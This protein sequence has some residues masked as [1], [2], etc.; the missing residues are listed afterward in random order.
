MSRPCLESWLEFLGAR[1]FIPAY[2]YAFTAKHA[3][4]IE[5]TFG[6]RYGFNKQVGVGPRG[7]YVGYFAPEAI[8]ENFVDGR[9][10]TEGEAHAR[11]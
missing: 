11:Q 5:G 7:E 6:Y 9:R 10:P 4:I 1:Q 3:Q 8:D 2:K